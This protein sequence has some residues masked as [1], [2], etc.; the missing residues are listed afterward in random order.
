MSFGYILIGGFG[1][2][3]AVMI[4]LVLSGLGFGLNVPNCSAWLLSKV[5]TNARGKALGGLT[6]AIFLGHIAAPFVY[7]PLVHVL[8]SGNTFL[9]VAVVSMLI[10]LIVKILSGQA[11]LAE[12]AKHG[13]GI[14]PASRAPE[15]RA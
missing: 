9:S 10:A 2:L 12:F 6:S 13:D 3:A 14:Q 15:T 1:S 5:P 11:S 4:G 7:D 8:G